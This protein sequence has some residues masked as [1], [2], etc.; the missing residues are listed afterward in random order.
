M[1][2]LNKFSAEVKGVTF[3]L[4]IIIAICI[5][6]AIPGYIKKNNEKVLVL[7]M[8]EIKMDSLIRT[9][10]FAEDVYDVMPLGLITKRDMSDHAG[11]HE[12]IKAYENAYFYANDSIMPI[13]AKYDN[14]KSR[15][16]ENKY[17]TIRTTLHQ[18]KLHDYDL[19][20]EELES[21]T[22]I[23]HYEW[24]KYTEKEFKSKLER[25]R[26]EHEVR[27]KEIYV[28]RWNEIKITNKE[29]APDGV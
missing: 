25:D 8:C 3:T 12:L 7:K 21:I 26:K 13:V 23:E 1:K 15:D 10:E 18:Y 6:V 11:T 9:V 4:I 19:F 5:G 27:R 28:P 24:G 17:E 20:C 2:V 22:Y 14:E 29:N 16:I